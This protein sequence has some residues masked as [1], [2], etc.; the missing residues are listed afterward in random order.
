[1]MLRTLCLS[2]RHIQHWC[3]PYRVFICTQ[4]GS[5]M[6]IWI[7]GRKISQNERAQAITTTTILIMMRKKR[8][9]IERERERFSE[10]KKLYTTKNANNIFTK[11]ERQSV[12]STAAAAAMAMEKKKEIIA[13]AISVVRLPPSFAIFR[14]MWNLNF[15]ATPN[16]THSNSRVGSRIEFAN[17]VRMRHE[18]KSYNFRTFT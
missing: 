6:H 1:M 18:K 3:W 11:R 16:L 9:K 15:T 13:L 8:R 7:Y 14:E 10:K 17:L 4:M 5:C 2:L 12:A